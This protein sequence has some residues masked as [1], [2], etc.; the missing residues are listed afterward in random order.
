MRGCHV[1]STATQL[2]RAMDDAW[3]IRIRILSM[4]GF[5]MLFACSL[6]CNSVEPVILEP[7]KS[8]TRNPR[9]SYLLSPV[10]GPP[11]E[12]RLQHLGHSCRIDAGLVRARVVHVQALQCRSGVDCL[13][14]SRRQ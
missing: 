11:N 3:K 13:T 4:T 1:R 10:H 12:L 14:G 5:G 9:L 8:A 6:Q 2:Q 7:D